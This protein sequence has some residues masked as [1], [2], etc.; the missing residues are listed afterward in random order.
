M[1]SAAIAVTLTSD[2]LKELAKCYKCDC[3]TRGLC[4]WQGEPCTE[5]F[6]LNTYAH[7]QPGNNIGTHAS[8]EASGQQ[9]ATREITKPQIEQVST[10]PNGDCLYECIACALNELV[11]IRDGGRPIT[12]DDLRAFVSRSQNSETFGVY[13]TLADEQPEYACLRSAHTLRAF[14]NIIRRCGRDAGPR[15]CLWG[16]ENTLHAIAEAYRL[17][18][19]VFNEKGRLIQQVQVPSQ[20]CPVMRTVLLRLNNLSPGE[21]HF[22]LLQFNGHSLLLD[23]E[24]GWISQ[25]LGGLE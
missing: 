4:T 20:E 24:W 18:F 25:R 14:K 11:D 22:E 21:E 17:R 23:N 12:I 10:K 7:L 1:N 16:D 5:C 19:A 9:Q 2:E 15:G 8:S 13:R 6:N 3:T